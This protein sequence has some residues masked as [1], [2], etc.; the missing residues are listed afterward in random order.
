MTEVWLT[1]LVGLVGSPHCI[2]MCGGIVAAV[3]MTSREGTPRS[4]WLFQLLYNLGRVTTYA[5]LGML[6]GLFGS[7]LSLL[8]LKTT[9]GWVF[10]AANLMV[11]LLGLASALRMGP[12]TFSTLESDASH[13]LARPLRWAI[14]G[15]TLLRAFPLGLI[16]GFMPCG[17]VYTPLLA[18]AA[19]GSPFQGGAMMA[20][21]GIGTM[22]LLLSF[23]AISTTL[24]SRIRGRMFR[25]VGVLLALVGGTGLWRVMGKMGYLPRFP[26][27]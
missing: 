3:A 15:S 26:F 5:F 6:A 8:T 2:G 1:F 16:L 21:L 10:A 18:A 22:P 9:A 19:S 27:W 23:G 20:A 11:L 25:L 24:S 4:R 12:F 7:S 14:S 13:L 17:L